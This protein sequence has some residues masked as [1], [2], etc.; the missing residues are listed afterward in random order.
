MKELFSATLVA[1]PADQRPIEIARTKAR[2]YSQL[3]EL[4]TDRESRFSFGFEG[5]T[6]QNKYQF[7]GHRFLLS[8]SRLAGDIGGLPVAEALPRMA[9][10]V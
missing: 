6:V 4:D 10:G 3:V 5:K 1:K 9:A 7:R 8:A 2:C